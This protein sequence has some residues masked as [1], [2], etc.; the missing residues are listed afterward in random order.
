MSSKSVDKEQEQANL[1][2]N[3]FISKAPVN[4][5]HLVIEFSN[6][7]KSEKIHYIYFGDEKI[8]FRE[9]HSLYQSIIRNEFAENIKDFIKVKSL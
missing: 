3:D 2:G 6:F 8:P 7:G 5:K 9:R 1:V 4:F